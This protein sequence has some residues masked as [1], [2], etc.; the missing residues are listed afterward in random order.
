MA[1]GVLQAPGSEYGPCEQACSHID[2]AETRRI[3]AS[4][5]RLCATPIEYERRFYVDTVQG[6]GEPTYY[7]HAS[8]AER[9]EGG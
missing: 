4:R 2:C 6:V 8:C 7:I 3:A 1:A 5:C 9:S